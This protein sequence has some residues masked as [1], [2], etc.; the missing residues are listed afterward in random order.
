MFVRINERLRQS[1]LSCTILAVGCV[2]VGFSLTANAADAS[3]R[4][5]AGLK[6]STD[7]PLAESNRVFIAEIEHRGLTLTRKGFPALSATLQKNNA[8][9]LARFLAPAFRGET[10]AVTQG[11][12]LENEVLQIRRA[13]TTNE[14]KARPEPAEAGA[15]VKYLLGLRSHFGKDA[16]VEL[17]LMSLSP[18]EPGN[19]AGAW[20]GSCALRMFGGR[21]GGGKSELLA[22][23]EFDLLRVPDVDVIVTDPGWI[24]SL[25][26]YGLQESSCTHDLMAEVAKERGIDRALF[27]DNWKMP[28]EERVNVTGGV[29]L[30]DIDND[31]RQDVLVL[32]AKGVFL[33]HALADGRYE[34]ISEKAGLPRK[35]TKK[36]SDPRPALSSATSAVFGDFD[37]D[38]LV[39]LIICDHTGAQ[40]FRN[41]GSGR[42]EDVTFL[43]K[44][45]FDDARSITGLTVGD[46]D[47]DGLL[48][49]YIT[50][51]GNGPKRNSVQVNSWID[52]PGGPGNQLWHNHGN[53][54]FE[55]VSKTANA[56]AGF[57]SCFTAAWL[58]ANND[59]WPDIY[60]INEFGGGI[61]L[62]NQANG[63]FKEVHLLDDAG[64]FGSMGMC[65]GDFDNDGNID[66][67]TAN[68]YS[69]AGRRI[70][71]N[72]PASS[73]PPNVFAKMKRFV[74]GSEIYRNHGGLNFERSGKKL[75]VHA[76]GWA[77]APT[78]VDLDNDG[79][80]DIYATAGFASAGREEPDG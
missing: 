22:K 42:F 38:G 37:N 16:K 1:W 67:Y 63:T 4:L 66:I 59:G 23:L 64:D 3:S 54:Q 41:L 17:A 46:F 75:D 27:Q 9:Q 56:T 14:P 55:E 15:F 5:P 40:V 74:T 62:V 45:W 43:T 68:M 29:Y 52:G 25:R 24:Q 13:S 28:A 60:C 26:V 6:P 36:K 7:I 78:F 72:L 11:Q 31:G 30:A 2:L 48:D 47:K 51:G 8:D 33:F 58:D 76:V 49:I 70:M 12:G 50:R 34:E 65:V 57:R 79:F 20:K 10:L 44:L 53:W 71:E 21:T 18:L 61:L 35:P 77:Y 80:L 32:D 19:L 69:K 39:D 73:Y